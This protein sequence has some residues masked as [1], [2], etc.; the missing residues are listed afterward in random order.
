MEN[1]RHIVTSRSA[2]ISCPFKGH[3]NFSKISGSIDLSKYKCWKVLKT[4]VSD[5]NIPRRQKEDQNV[6]EFTVK[7]L[8]FWKPVILYLTVFSNSY[9]YDCGPQITTEC[10]H[11]HFE[12]HASFLECL[13]QA[14]SAKSRHFLRFGVFL[15]TTHTRGLITMRHVVWTSNTL[16]VNQVEVF[17]YSIA[18]NSIKTRI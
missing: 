2:I 4:R 8:R 5:L 7:W 15:F 6:H 17:L 11:K 10:S 3:V 1:P 14:M 16:A 9:D 18:A 13:H 12:V